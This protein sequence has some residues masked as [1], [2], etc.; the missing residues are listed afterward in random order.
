MLW[1]PAVFGG[2]GVLAIGLLVSAVVGPRWGPLGA[3]A[4]ALCFPL[5]HV[6]RSTYSEPP[7]ILVLAAGLLV[8]VAATAR[9]ER[10][11]REHAR[12][13]GFLAGVLI[14][15]GGLV[16]VDALRETVLLLPVAALLLVRRNA[17]GAPLLWGAGAA[18]AVSAA[19]ALGLSSRYVGSIAASLLPLVLLGVLLA[20]LAAGVVLAARRGVRLPDRVRDVLPRGCAVLV[21]LAGVLLATRPLWRTERQSAADPGSRVVAGLQL[22][23]GLPVDG[24]RTYAEQSLA[25]TAWWTGPVAIAVA[26]AVLA[27][28]GSRLARAWV[29]GERLPAWTGPY[30]VGLASVLLTWARPGITPD[31]PWADRRLF[32]VLPVVIVC[33]VAGAAWLTRWST[34]RMSPGVLVVAS[35]GTAGLLLVPEAMATLPHAGERVEAGSSQAVASVCRALAPGDVALMVDGRAANEWPQVVRGVCGVPALS[36]TAPVRQDEGRRARAVAAVAREVSRSGRHLVLLAADSPQALSVPP[37]SGLRLG[38]PAEV[39]DVLVREDARLLERRP[40]STV[41]LPLRVWLAPV[42]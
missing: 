20:V 7:A 4:S 30:L 9:G 22:R 32:I 1:L 18:T 12:I 34:R 6:N 35:V 36:L 24:G 13:L 33:V 26:F 15:G 21:V 14:G 10:G 28:A 3:F 25:W 27:L 38:A 8:L 5:L 19:A 42:R 41:G 40:D 39:T 17:A 37:G 16:R 31:H 29:R 11:H 23:Q 2:L